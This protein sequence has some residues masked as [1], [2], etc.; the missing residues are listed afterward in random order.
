MMSQKR[1]LQILVFSDFYVVALCSLGFT[2]F[3]SYTEQV[4][5]TLT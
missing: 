5:R 2:I 4:W 3:G 1:R